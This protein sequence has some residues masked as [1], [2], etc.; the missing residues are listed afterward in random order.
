MNED[1]LKK[2]LFPYTCDDNIHKSVIQAMLDNPNTGKLI[3]IFTKQEK[4]PFY[5]VTKA[6]YETQ[7]SF[8]LK[9][10]NR[11]EIEFNEE[12]M[13]HM[14]VQV[15]NNASEGDLDRIL[16][17]WST[18]FKLQT[19]KEKRPTHICLVSDS[20]KAALEFDA[21]LNKNGLKKSMA[22]F[23]VVDKKLYVL[24]GIIDEKFNAANNLVDYKTER[25]AFSGVYVSGKGWSRS[26]IPMKFYSYRNHGWMHDH[27]IRN[28]CSCVTDLKTMVRYKELREFRT[29]DPKL[30]PFRV[31]KHLAYEA[32]CSS[33]NPQRPMPTVH[34]TNMTEEEL[35]KLK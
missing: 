35:N 13:G 3:E 27:N 31:K 28:Y 2:F 16:A 15:L 7:I 18:N 19:A 17:T 25:E 12:V 23:A 29:L 32:Q 11:L 33:H 8:A 20:R 21:F 14:L 6:G 30:A 1:D 34:F 9:L 5:N 4:I 10:L 24:T 26:Q 22:R